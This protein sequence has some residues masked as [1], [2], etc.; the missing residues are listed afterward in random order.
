MRQQDLYLSAE[1][2]PA[3][4]RTVQRQA[5]AGELHRIAAG[6]YTPLP[7]ADWP[8]LLT[9]ERI[10]FLAAQFPGAVV[11]YRSA[12]E[13]LGGKDGVVFLS[14]SYNRVIEYPGLTVALVKGAGAQV[15][16]QPMQNRPLYFSSQ[17]RL[18]LENLVIDRHPLHRCAP[19]DQVEARL[20]TICATRGEA[21]LNALRDQARDLAPVLGLL[22]E[23]EKLNKMVGA[24]SSGTGPRRLLTH[25]AAR[26]A[27]NGLPYD[28]GRMA[29]FDRL[30][31]ALR[32]QVFQPVPHATLNP[33]ALRNQAF[34]ESYFSNF[35]EG[36]EFEVGEA[37]D[38][39]LNGK[40]MEKRPKDSHDII[41]VFNQINHLGWRS[42]VLSTT[43]HIL[44]QL[45]ARHADL[46]QARPETDP[47]QFK[48]RMN[49]AGNTAF[50]APELVRGT[51][52]EGARRSTDVP[53]GMPRAL[54]AM[55]LVAETHPFLDG[56]GRLARLAMN[57]EL[58][59]AGEQ[60]IIVP[61]LAREEYLDCLRALT[62]NGDTDGFISIMTHLQRWSASFKY[63]DLDAVIAAMKGCNAFE[64]SRAQFKLL[65]PTDR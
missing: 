43:P 29:L 61:T 25:P 49:Y 40:I 62:R 13:G 11:G 48:N 23:L 34:L 46:M 8:T 28:Q 26:A 36:T 10:R 30:V 35:I 4:R 33:T 24:I 31:A 6:V 15:G 59:S 47:G 64:R 65:M 51:L 9:R 63:D 16:D 3:E 50:A 37:R 22:R 58:S 19:L 42:Q 38:I 55:F 27:A 12:F 2:T 1:L 56:N 60:R 41:G 54:F 20:V 21:A 17:P 18:M 44:E 53:P 7:E 45:Q 57:A 5:K 14:S 32:A 52:T 39:V